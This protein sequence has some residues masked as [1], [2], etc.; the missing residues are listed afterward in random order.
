MSFTGKSVKL[1]LKLKNESTWIIRQE[2][3]SKWFSSN[4]GG[5]AKLDK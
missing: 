1:N 4:V 3:G 5:P 2:K